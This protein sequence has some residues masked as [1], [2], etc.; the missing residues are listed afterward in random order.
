M[1]PIFLS[2]LCKRSHDQRMQ[3]LKSFKTSFGRDL[4]SDV[5]SETS[6]NFCKVLLG[7]LTPIDE[8]IAKELHDAMEGLGKKLNY[9]QL[10]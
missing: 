6:S 3:L 9:Q 1:K 4:Y 7:L 8:Y 5:K 10:G 2:V